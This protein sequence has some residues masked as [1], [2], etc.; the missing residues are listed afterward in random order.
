MPD[1]VETETTNDSTKSDDAKSDESTDTTDWKAEAE[2]WKS[3]AR[4]HETAFKG[5]SKELEAFKAQSMTDQEKAI[6]EAKKNGANEA[7][8]L[9]GS[10]LV[11]SE[12]KVGL[13]GRISDESF[14]SLVDGLNVSKFLTDDG[15]VDSDAVAAFVKALAPAE[16]KSTKKSLDLGQGNRGTTTSLANDNALE[17]SIL[18][19]VGMRQSN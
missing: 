12:L 10:K 1:N 9:Y 2:K 8:Q 16:D 11:V 17:Q 13:N 15:D 14:N 5:T 18:K 7:K 6:E 4:K 19:A 3:L